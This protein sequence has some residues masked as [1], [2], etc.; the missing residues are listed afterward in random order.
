M[1]RIIIVVRFRIVLAI[2]MIYE[3]EVVATCYN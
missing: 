3:L 2:V 1:S